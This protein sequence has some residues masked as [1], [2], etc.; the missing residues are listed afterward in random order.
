MTMKLS[1][2]TINLSGLAGRFG[3]MFNLNDSRWGRADD[4]KPED[5]GPGKP[6]GEP[7]QK[8]VPPAAEERPRPTP[9]PGAQSGPPDLDELWRDFNRK[10]NGW[11][12]G[13]KKP[14]GGAGRGPGD[15]IPNFKGAGIGGGVILAVVFLVCVSASCSKVSTV[16]TASPMSIRKCVKQL[17][18]CVRWARLWKTCRCPCTWMDRPFGPPL[19]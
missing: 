5:G 1:I 12:G 7:E 8:D 14:P 9:R 3:R 17:I 19:P 6:Q 2:P 15:F 10:L 11:L 4:A 16:Q 13:G 18:A